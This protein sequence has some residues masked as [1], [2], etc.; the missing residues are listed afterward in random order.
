MTREGGSLL[1]AGE[2]RRARGAMHSGR[3]FLRVSRRNPREETVLARCDGQVQE[4]TGSV[5]LTVSSVN[6]S[7]DVPVPWAGES[8]V[9]ASSSGRCPTPRRA[10]RRGPTGSSPS[11][12]DVAGT[13]RREPVFLIAGP[14]RLTKSAIERPHARANNKSMHRSFTRSSQSRWQYF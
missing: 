13:R 1:C 3:R 14:I 11:S 7:C 8:S 5:P 4:I 9:V 12:R 6:E 10:I 2:N